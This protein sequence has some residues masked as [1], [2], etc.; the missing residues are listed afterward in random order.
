MM[1]VSL[2]FYILSH[3]YVLVSILFVAESLIHNNVSVITKFNTVC[4]YKPI[5]PLKVQ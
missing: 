5:I 1:A 3:A 4:L 2:N